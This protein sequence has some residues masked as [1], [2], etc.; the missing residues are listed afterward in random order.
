MRDK[1]FQVLA[2]LL[3][4]PGRVDTREELHHCLWSESRAW[5]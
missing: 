4:R 5:A 3:E 2:A 1:S